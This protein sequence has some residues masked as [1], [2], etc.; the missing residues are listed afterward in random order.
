MLISVS[1][2]VGIICLS[3]VCSDDNR[4]RV[5]QHDGLQAILATFK[6]KHLADIAIPTAFNIC[7]DYGKYFDEDVEWC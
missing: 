7:N 3:N 1:S 2:N 5:L 6:N 4:E